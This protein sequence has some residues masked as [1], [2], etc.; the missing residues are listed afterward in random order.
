M[1]PLLSAEIQGV[2][3]PQRQ[4]TPL[5][6]DVILTYLCDPR[7]PQELQA[8][9]D[10]TQRQLA[11]TLDQ[12]GIAQRRLQ[13]LTSELE[14]V[15][16]NC[17][18]ALRAKRTAEQAYEEAQSRINELTTINVNLASSRSKLEQELGTLAG[19]YEEV[20]KELRVSVW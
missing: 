10:E 16:S 6:S 15:R 7:Q 4:V 9:Y 14:E 3:G 19:D 20:T 2:L 18:T 1:P 12:Y 17:E 8:H 11:V 5:H 13:S